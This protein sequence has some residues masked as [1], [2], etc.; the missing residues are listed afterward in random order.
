[1]DPDDAPRA[2]AVRI[3]SF[4]ESQGSFGG[5]DSR[6]KASYQIVQ[7]FTNGGEIEWVIR[8]R[9][10]NALAACNGLLASQKMDV[11]SAAPVSR[12]SSSSSSSSNSPA[13]RL[14]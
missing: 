9:D 13:G 6:S 7:Y 12:P 4:R 2:T 10:G 14:T 11:F 3:A 8:A 5:L 1:M